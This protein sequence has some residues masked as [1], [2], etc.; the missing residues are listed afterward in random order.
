[1]TMRADAGMRVCGDRGAAAVLA[2]TLSAAILLCVTAAVAGG[3]LLVDHRRAAVAA[4]LAALA[5]AAAVQHGLD[6][7]SAA[8]RIAARND[9]VVSGCRVTGEEV[10]VTVRV[11]SVRLLGRSVRPRADAR[12]GP[13]G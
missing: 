5:G 7:C 8:E 12:A 1:M 3:R 9:A 6:G 13:V 10:L 11:A 2:V 4:D